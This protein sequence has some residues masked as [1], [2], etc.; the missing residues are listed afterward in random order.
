M[1]AKVRIPFCQRRTV[2][3]SSDVRRYPTLF[4]LLYFFNISIL[5]IFPMRNKEKKHFM[6]NIIYHID[7]NFFIFFLIFCCSVVLEDQLHLSKLV[8]L[9]VL[10]VGKPE[11]KLIFIMLRQK[12]LLSTWYRSLCKI[13]LFHSILSRV[14]SVWKLKLNVAP[15]TLEM[16]VKFW[17]NSL[18]K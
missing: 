1:A 9:P 17:I 18:V 11:L 7:H 4:I 12:M 15:L 5:F 8:L 13:L 2:F 6:F 16:F 10:D 3:S 14:K